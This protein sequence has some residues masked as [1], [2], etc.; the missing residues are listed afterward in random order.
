MFPTGH[1]RNATADLVGILK[2]KHELMAS[3]ALGEK[4]GKA[5]YEKAHPPR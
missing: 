3:L 2:H 1:A 4:A 5:F